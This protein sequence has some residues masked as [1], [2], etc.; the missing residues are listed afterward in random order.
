MTESELFATTP[1]KEEFTIHTNVGRSAFDALQNQ[2]EEFFGQGGLSQS[3]RDLSEQAG[4]SVRHEPRAGSRIPH[5]MSGQD[6]RG[7]SHT[8]DNAATGNTYPD[9]TLHWQL[10]SVGRSGNEREVH[11]VHKPLELKTPNP[12]RTSPPPQMDLSASVEDMYNKL[13]KIEATLTPKKPEVREAVPLT[14]PPPQDQ[15]VPT[16]AVTLETQEFKEAEVVEPAE[17]PG[18]PEVSVCVLIF[19]FVE[20]VPPVR[21]TE[22]IS[23]TSS[24][25]S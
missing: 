18:S 1:Q 5:G 25:P 24:V 22:L 3:M 11:T 14:P 23:L 7:F 17:A 15:P 16:A 6:V 20:I 8:F 19:P 12:D 4:A 13:G 21:A 9:N 10:Q 2:A